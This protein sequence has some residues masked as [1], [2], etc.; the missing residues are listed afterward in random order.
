MTKTTDSCAH[1][2]RGWCNECHH[3]AIE[4]VRDQL[5][6][7]QGTSLKLSEKNAALL[8]EVEKLKA[9]LA[10]RGPKIHI[11]QTGQIN[12]LHAVLDSKL[13]SGCRGAVLITLRPE[14][15]CIWDAATKGSI[16]H[17]ELCMIGQGL[18]KLVLDMRPMNVK[19]D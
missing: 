8:V 1:R 17:A 4:P 19:S 7:A 14:V 16:S 13:E 3:S 18:T 2:K 12:D 10:D 15:D 5:K 9:E 6:A 11:L